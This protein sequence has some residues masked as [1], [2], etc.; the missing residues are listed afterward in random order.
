[1]SRRTFLI[2]GRFLEL[3]GTGVG[4]YALETV[5]ELDKIC[6]SLDVRLLI[7][8]AA[9]MSPLG[10]LQNIR[11][12]QS[13][14]NKMWTQGVF[15][16]H[17]LLR[18]AIPINFCNEASMLAP[19]GIVCLHDTCYAD[20]P[21]FFSEEE[22][23]WFAKVYTRVAKK[24]QVILTV[25]EFSRQAIAEVLSVNLEKIVVAG[26]GWQHFNVVEED[27]AVFVQKELEGIKKGQYYFTLSSANP[28]KNLDWIV[29]AS[30]V[31]R[32]DE[33]IVAGHGID[34]IVD[35]SKYPNMHY[36]G[37]ASDG[38]VKAL[39]KHCRAFIF[40]SFYEGFGIP[41]LEAL[42]AGAQI[43]VSN[44][45]SLPEVFG[46]CAHYISPDNAM[47][48]FESLLNEPV[49]PAKEVL[50]KYSWEKTAQVVLSVMQ[51]CQN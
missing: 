49:K 24:A 30:T 11:V 19:K 37:A 9:D 35:F 12:I 25:S 36:V 18:F 31:N 8:K 28:N 32:N 39:M 44:Q 48:H 16:F 43:I 29:Q 13:R 26:N 21:Q 2:D 23:R 40:P 27:E 41:P 20:C 47:V 10:H 4:R 22:V 45:A 50:D 46:D 14:W 15:A 3:L 17:A 5:K 1:M 42:S 6:S 7:P 34:R 33:F 51:S 38:Q